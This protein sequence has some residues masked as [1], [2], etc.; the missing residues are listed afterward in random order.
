MK[1][2]KKNSGRKAGERKEEEFSS[3]KYWE[4]RYAKGGNS[5]MGSY[6]ELAM[7]K[8]DFLNS[9]VSEHKI[10]KIIEFGCGDGN[11]LALAN[12]PKYIGLDISATIIK[13]IIKKFDQDSTKSFFLYHPFCFEDN[14]NIFKS[15]LAL[16]LDVIYHI[17]ED[18]VYEAYMKS[19]F[20][21]SDRFVII[22]SSNFDQ[23]GSIH[24]KHR[25][26]LKWVE[27]NLKE[28]DLFEKVDNKHP[29]LSSAQF[30]VFKKNRDSA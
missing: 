17:V 5:G 13:H 22:Y 29:N 1:F 10:S 8:A 11:Q 18:D 28:W 19:L 16:S 12:Y 3:E 24:V 20:N 21:C 9:F 14:L 23:Q 26:F 27:A 25:A 6:N 7:F 2:F 30:Y 15:S 4:E